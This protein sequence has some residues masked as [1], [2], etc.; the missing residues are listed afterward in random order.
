MAPLMDSAMTL[1]LYRWVV[2]SF[3][4]MLIPLK[5]VKKNMPKVAKMAVALVKSN[6]LPRSSLISHRHNL[7]NLF[8]VPFSSFQYSVLP[9]VVF[10]RQGE[11]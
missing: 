10:I 1:A 4:L 8:N 7:K 2:R 11:Y 3:V 9:Y 5:A 6:A